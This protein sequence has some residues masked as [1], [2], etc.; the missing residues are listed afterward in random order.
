MIIRHVDTT[1][2]SIVIV[3]LDC[4]YATP[5]SLYLWGVNGALNYNANQYN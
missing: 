3:R 2:W 4:N 5:S 1:P